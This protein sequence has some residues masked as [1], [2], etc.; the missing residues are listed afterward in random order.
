MV[1]HTSPQVILELASLKYPAS[2]LWSIRKATQQASMASFGV[3]GL[4]YCLS[5]HM[6]PIFLCENSKDLGKTAR[7]CIALIIFLLLYIRVVI[8]KNDS[9]DS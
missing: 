5:L 2:C 8:C 1:S 3:T 7:I 9:I 6:W 4:N